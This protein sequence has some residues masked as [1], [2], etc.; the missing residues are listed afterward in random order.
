[1]GR[2]VSIGGPAS[3]AD[4]TATIQ[5][6]DVVAAQAK[7]LENRVGRG[8]LKVA[9]TW[10]DPD[11]NRTAFSFTRTGT[12]KNV[13]IPNSNANAADVGFLSLVGSMDELGA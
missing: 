12:I 11:G 3:R 10:L 2:Q 8:R 5:F 7:A 6:S 9:I 1:M 13:A 4:V